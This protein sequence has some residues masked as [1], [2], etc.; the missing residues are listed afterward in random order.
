MAEQITL[1]GLAKKLDD[2][3]KFMTVYKAD[4]E[5]DE[6]EKDAAAKKAQDEKEENDKKEAKRAASYRSALK[7]AMD[8][9]DDKKMESAVKKAMED[10]CPNKK[11]AMDDDH[12]KDHT[13][14][15]EEDK[16][17]KA[18]VASIIEDKKQDYI[19]KILTA[20]TIFN[21]TNLKAIEARL[22]KASITKVKE[23]WSVLA[24]AFEGAVEQR[25]PQQKF[26]P[27]YANAGQ[28]DA[29]QLNA[30][31]P[32][33]EFAKLSTKEITEMYR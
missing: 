24:P 13:A 17:H 18:H 29:D 7:K 3:S 14:M 23:E 25:P 4:H 2:V 5:T 19:K 10:H 21:P 30:S 27:F 26:V 15:D 16:E 22:K 8:E 32:D 6:K 31:S 20:N 1:E 28:T 33:S 11:E 12:P 9:D